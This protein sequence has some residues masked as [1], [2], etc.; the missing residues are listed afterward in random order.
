[1]FIHLL[2]GIDMRHDVLL[3]VVSIILPFP[4]FT[5]ACRAQGSA[6]GDSLR[7]EILQLAVR[8]A[9]LEAEGTDLRHRL[10]PRVELS[11]GIGVRDLLFA[12]TAAADAYL[13][14]KDSYRLSI[15]LNIGG[16]VD[17]APHERALIAL[18][19]RRTEL[20]L[21]EA[22][23][24]Q[25]RRSAQLEA[26]RLDTLRSIH[27]E[28]LALRLDVVRFRAM[29]FEQGKDGFDDLVR[30]KLAVLAARR[31]SLLV[32]PSAEVPERER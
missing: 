26:S 2:E 19:R 3:F 15:G 21:A 10:M 12:G 1:M 25:A 30:A 13:L 6:E 4:W 9:E 32:L 5:L 29:L 31:S 17:A 14:P 11:A 27:A 28:E 20:A 22:R 8:D 24:R 7:R 16:L 18:S 23:G